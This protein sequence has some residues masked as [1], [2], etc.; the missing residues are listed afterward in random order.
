MDSGGTG[1]GARIAPT[2]TTGLPGR[3]TPRGLT[4][5]PFCETLEEVTQNVFHPARVDKWIDAGN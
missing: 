3:S 2:D 1:R 4:E 5:L